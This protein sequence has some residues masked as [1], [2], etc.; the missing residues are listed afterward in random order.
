MIVWSDH[1]GECS[2]EKDCWR[3]VATDVLQLANQD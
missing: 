2:P 3:V 1:L